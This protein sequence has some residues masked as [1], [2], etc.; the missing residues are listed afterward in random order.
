MQ[1]KLI[2][3]LSRACPLQEDGVHLTAQEADQLGVVS[4][5]AAAEDKI[6]PFCLG[7]G[8]AVAR[9]NDMVHQL[10][11]THGQAFEPK[12]IFQRAQGLGSREI[13]LHIGPFR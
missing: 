7:R 1:A 9:L 2:C 6:S 4:G 8:I 5:G 3:K 11:I 12:G 10:D 13:N